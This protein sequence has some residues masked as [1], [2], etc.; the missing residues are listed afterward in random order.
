MGESWRV[1]CGCTLVAFRKCK[2]NNRHAIIVYHV[3]SISCSFRCIV[4][5]HSLHVHCSMCMH[6]ARSWHKQCFYLTLS[7]VNDFRSVLES[8]ARWNCTKNSCMFATDCMRTQ[9]EWEI[10]AWNDM[11]TA[12]QNTRRPILDNVQRNTHTAIGIRWKHWKYAAIEFASRRCRAIM[13]D[14]RNGKSCEFIDCKCTTLTQ[15]FNT[16]SHSLVLAGMVFDRRFIICKRWMPDNKMN[17]KLRSLNMSNWLLTMC[18][19]V[20]HLRWIRCTCNLVHDKSIK[21]TANISFSPNEHLFRCV[22][23]RIGAAATRSY[24]FYIR[25]SI[26]MNFRIYVFKGKVSDFNNYCCKIEITCEKVIY[27]LF[28]PAPSARCQSPL[29]RVA[30]QPRHDFKLHALD[31]TQFAASRTKSESEGRAGTFCWHRFSF[32]L[33]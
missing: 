31:S 30:L 33:L 28:F 6:A 16:L 15:Q 19:C 9:C 20:V 12:P 27:F 26:A 25:Q 29:E 24:C 3:L 10:Q 1:V 8:A 7:F 2:Q 14:S 22:R 23:A 18:S 5:I 17:E 13:C 11:L 32:S 4:S 21:R